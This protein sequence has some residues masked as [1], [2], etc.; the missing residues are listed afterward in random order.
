MVARS[1]TTRKKT[2]TMRDVANYAAVSQST[3]SRILNDSGGASLISEETRERVYE[4]V[5]VLSYRPNLHAGALR[6]YMTKMVAV[7]IGDIGNPFYH[8]LVRAI[9]DVASRHE[10]DVIV[11]NTDYDEQGERRFLESI[12]RRP[13]DGVILVPSYLGNREI[14]QVID[15]TGA[16]V[17]IVGEHIHHPGADHVHNDD[18]PATR[19][20]ILWLAR[21]R[22]YRRIAYIGVNSAAATPTRRLN[23]YRA[24]MED[25]G[26]PL[27]AEY[28]LAGDWTPESGYQAMEQLLDL[29]SPPD[30]IFAANDLM[31]LGAMK[32]IRRRGLGTPEDVA[33]MG[34]DDIPAASWVSPELTTI[35]PYPF[36][37][38]IAIAE[39]LFERLAGKYSGPGREY[40]VP[41]HRIER[42]ST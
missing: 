10:Y 24:A 2:V 38:G 16:A 9:Q 22:N 37:M 17:G 30:A 39:A 3:V 25:L 20:A 32:A 35:A 14:E 31:A 29:P 13:V 12:L 40:L 6:G 5:R 33:V 23:A 19:A 36:E 42:G 1:R 15:R 41:C 21:T 7:M 11:T 27:R 18:G 4:A 28:I 8:P 26:E 34:I